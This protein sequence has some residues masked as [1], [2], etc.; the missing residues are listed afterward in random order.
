MW[1]T[2]LRSATSSTTCCAPPSPPPLQL[3]PLLLKLQAPQAHGWFQPQTLLTLTPKRQKANR[4]SKTLHSLVST[5]H[6]LTINPIP[7][8]TRQMFSC[9]DFLRITWM[10]NWPEEEKLRQT[11]KLLTNAASWRLW[12]IENSWMMDPDG[13]LALVSGVH[14]D[15][16]QHWHVL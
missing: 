10:Q 3:T 6:P 12:C 11:S 1:R 16:T 5:M 8:S 14:D 2:S 15:W 4:K 13:E 7:N 9:A